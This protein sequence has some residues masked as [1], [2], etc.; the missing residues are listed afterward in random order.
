MRD[1][2]VLHDFITLERSLFAFWSDKVWLHHLT[3]LNLSYSSKK[4]TKAVSSMGRV[5]AG[6]MEAPCKLDVVSAQHCAQN[7]LDRGREP[8]ERLPLIGRRKQFVTGEE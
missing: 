1:E 7:N 4:M 2:T 3:S 8:C 6:C 5:C